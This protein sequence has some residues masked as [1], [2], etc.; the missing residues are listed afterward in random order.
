MQTWPTAKVSALAGEPPVRDGQEPV[1][2]IRK[3]VGLVP[4]RLGSVPAFKVLGMSPVSC[5]VRV[6][7]SSVTSRLPTEVGVGKSTVAVVRTTV[8]RPSVLSLMRRSP[9]GSTSMP[10]GASRGMG[11]TTLPLVAEVSW[12]TNWSPVTVDSTICLLP[13]SAM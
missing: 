12:R 4:V 13:R 6:S 3:A 1:V 10:V 9:V 5:T 8:T 11:L 7:G 2:A